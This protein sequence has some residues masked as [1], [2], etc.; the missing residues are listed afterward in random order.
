MVRARYRLWL[1][2]WFGQGLR[3]IDQLPPLVLKTNN[4]TN[5][6]NYYALNP[7]TDCS[8]PYFW[9]AKGSLRTPFAI[10]AWRSLSLIVWSM[11]G[12]L[13]L[14]GRHSPLRVWGVPVWWDDEKHLCRQFPLES[15][16]V[17]VD[18]RSS[19]TCWSMHLL[20]SLEI[21]SKTLVLTLSLTGIRS[22]IRMVGE[23]L[24]YG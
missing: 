2:I 17:S 12:P 13:F 14:R 9:A 20:K 16:V 8:I 3:L 7:I 6:S 23:H 4:F 1:M 15:A 11:I 5:K 24:Y 18:G 10:E 22:S 21:Y 19:M